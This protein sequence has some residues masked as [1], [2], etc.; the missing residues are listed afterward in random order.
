MRFFRVLLPLKGIGKS[1]L[2]YALPQFFN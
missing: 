1:F 2:S